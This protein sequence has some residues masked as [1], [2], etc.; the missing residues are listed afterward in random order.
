MTQLVDPGYLTHELKIVVAAL[1]PIRVC[2]PRGHGCFLTWADRP[3]SRERERDNVAAMCTGCWWFTIVS[4]TSQT[5]AVIVSVLFFSIIKRMWVLRTKVYCFHYKLW[6]ETR[7]GWLKSHNT[8]L[9]RS[10]IIA[11]IFTLV[12]SI[13]GAI[14]PGV[15]VSLSYFVL[16]LSLWNSDCWSAFWNRRTLF[17]SEKRARCFGKS[18]E[19]LLLASR[20]FLW[21][22]SNMARIMDQN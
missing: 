13:T 4:E 11:Y 15:F 7:G 12:F 6:C 2:R 14:L 16:R 5:S 9:R 19:G 1:Q 21:G 10:T 17:F 22:G 20:L 3:A 8:E 18:R